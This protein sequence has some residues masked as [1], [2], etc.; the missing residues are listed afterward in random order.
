MLLFVDVGEGANHARAK[1]VVG[2]M[3]KTM[4][5]MRVSTRGKGRS[6]ITTGG[7]V[8]VEAKDGGAQSIMLSML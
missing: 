1:E 2:Q 6:E 3:R 5:V 8:G 4:L 7:L